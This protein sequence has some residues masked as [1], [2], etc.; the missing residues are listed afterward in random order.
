MPQFLTSFCM[1]VVMFLQDTE[2]HRR[3]MPPPPSHLVSSSHDR[4]MQIESKERELAEARQAE[5]RLANLDS[6]RR[7]QRNVNG[8]DTPT[9]PPPLPDVPPPDTTPSSG[10][11]ASSRLDMLVGGGGSNG[12]SV[13]KN[14]PAAATTTAG[15]P[16]KRV[17]FMNTSSNNAAED[18]STIINNEKLNRLERVEK[19]PNV[20]KY[21]HCTVIHHLK[22]LSLKR[23]RD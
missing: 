14:G 20:S 4:L 2:D 17:S 19:D 5:E 21:E 12:G 15:T 23:S 6:M 16:T 8:M 18:P 7:K 9:P 13:L 10:A 3:R 1:F 22:M 11:A